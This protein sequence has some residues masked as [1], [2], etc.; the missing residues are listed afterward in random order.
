MPLSGSDVETMVGR[1]VV[2]R[3][4]DVGTVEDVYL[5]RDTRRP[6]WA[7]VN[8]GLFGMKQSFVPLAMAQVE[9]DSIRV[10]YGKDDIENAPKVEPDGE[11]SEEEEAQLYRHYGREYSEAPSPPGSLSRAELPMMP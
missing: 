7:L 11:L 3:D 8:T 10:P 9:G 5:D 2:G 6:E 1:A 4:G